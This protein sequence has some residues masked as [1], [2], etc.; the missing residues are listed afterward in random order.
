MGDQYAKDFYEPVPP[1]A[2]AIIVLNCNTTANSLNL[3]TAGILS[4]NAVQGNQ[5]PQLQG[6]ATGM[7][8]RMVRF[9]AT[10][11]SVAVCF[12][13]SSA[14]VTGNNAPNT[15]NF[16]VNVL[17]G[18]AIINAGTYEDFWIHPDSSWLGYQATPGNATLTISARSRGY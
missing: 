16:G 10:G 18:A 1:I 17:G 7:V 5:V 15:A 12:N 2:G 14:G 8:Q 11:N 13:A 6:Q 3:A 9:R 4:V